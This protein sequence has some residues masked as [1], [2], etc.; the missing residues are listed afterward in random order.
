VELDIFRGR[1]SMDE[2]AYDVPY[3][4]S[5]FVFPSSLL[6]YKSIQALPVARKK[7]YKV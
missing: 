2:L 1:I 3:A 4:S 5:F 6:A 7:H